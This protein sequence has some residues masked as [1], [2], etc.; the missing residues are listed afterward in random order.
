MGLGDFSPQELRNAKKKDQLNEEEKDLAVRQLAANAS[1]DNVGYTEEAVS[2][3]TYGAG[4]LTT[5]LA[6]YA[7]DS[8]GFDELG[9]SLKK[10]SDSLLKKDNQHTNMGDSLLT[11]REEKSNTST[12][13]AEAAGLALTG[14]ASFLG[15]KIAGGAAKL[16]SSLAKRDLTEMTAKKAAEN[17]AKDLAEKEAID[18]AK[19]KAAREGAE[20]INDIGSFKDTRKTKE[21]LENGEIRDQA[22]DD[23]VNNTL[24]G[25]VNNAINNFAKRVEERKLKKEKDAALKE[26]E[27]V[28]TESVPT[29]RMGKAVNALF[30]TTD[31]MGV[32]KAGTK[33]LGKN[34]VASTYWGVL[35]NVGQGSQQWQKRGEDGN[36]HIGYTDEG[37]SNL[38]LDVTLGGVFDAV[39]GSAGKAYRASKEAKALKARKNST[40]TAG[41]TEGSNMIFRGDASTNKMINEKY[42]SGISDNMDEQGFIDL[43]KSNLV[44]KEK[45][46]QMTNSEKSDYMHEII[47]TLDENG[48]KGGSFR[49]EDTYVFKSPKM[50]T[51]TGEI[52]QNGYMTIERTDSLT[53]QAFGLQT[54]DGPLIDVG[55]DIDVH[56]REMKDPADKAFGSLEP[57]MSFSNKEDG[58]PVLLDKYGNEVPDNVAASKTIKD[59]GIMFDNSLKESGL[60]NNAV[61]DVSVLRQVRNKELENPNHE[62]LPTYLKETVELDGKLRDIGVKVDGLK[63]NYDSVIDDILNDLTDSSKG[64]KGG[65]AK[66][67]IENE[68]SILESMKGNDDY[69]DLLSVDFTQ[70]ILNLKNKDLS[71]KDLSK[72]I[73][74]LVDDT[75]SRFIQ[76]SGIGKDLPGSKDSI[77]SKMSNRFKEAIKKDDSKFGLNTIM[78]EV[79][80]IARY[81]DKYKDITTGFKHET[82]PPKSIIEEKR[83]I[84]DIGE[85]GK[86]LDPYNAKTNNPSLYKQAKREANQVYKPVKNID[87]QVSKIT[88]MVNRTK[89]N[90]EKDPTHIDK[91][92][93]NMF[94]DH[95]IDDINKIH[96]NMKDKIVEAQSKIINDMSDLGEFYNSRGGSKGLEKGVKF[97]SKISKSGRVFYNGSLNPK[98]NKI[99]RALFHQEGD[100]IPLS[101]DDVHVSDGKVH[102]KTDNANKTRTSILQNL[103]VK[104]VD[105]I[106]KPRSKDLDTIWNENIKT[107]HG[108]DGVKFEL[109]D[110]NLG[111]S[112]SG[113]GAKAHLELFQDI[114]NH[115]SGTMPIHIGYDAKA[116]GPAIINAMVGKGDEVFNYNL[117]TKKNPNKAFFGDDP[118]AKLNG[119]IEGRDLQKDIVR[120]AFYMQEPINTARGNFNS[121]V[122]EMFRLGT[123]SK[124][125]KEVASNKMSKLTEL[126]KG[127]FKDKPKDELDLLNITNEKQYTDLQQAYKNLTSGKKVSEDDLNL[128]RESHAKLLK[129]D[130]EKAVEKGFGK[131]M[132]DFLNHSKEFYK[133]QKI[134]FHTKLAEKKNKQEME[135][136]LADMLE[137]LNLDKKFGDQAEKIKADLMENYKNSAYK[138]TSVNDLLDIIG[139]DYMSHE[140]VNS[141]TLKKIIPS[142][143][144]MFGN[145]VPIFKWESS[146]FEKRKGKGAPNLQHSGPS[147]SEKALAGFIIDHDATIATLTRNKDGL[148]LYDDFTN[149]ARAKEANALMGA[150]LVDSK[151]YKA[152]HS[153]LSSEPLGELSKDQI[154]FAAKS[155][156]EESIRVNDLARGLKGKEVDELIKKH[157]DAN[158]I[159]IENSIKNKD[160]FI[161]TLEGKTKEEEIKKAKLKA[162]LEDKDISVNNYNANAT[163]DTMAGSDD[164]LKALDN[165]DKHKLNNKPIEE[166]IVKSSIDERALTEAYKLDKEAV[167]WNNHNTSLNL[168]GSTNRNIKVNI[169]SKNS[170]YKTDGSIHIAVNSK[171]KPR[172]TMKVII[173]EVS[174]KAADISKLENAELVNKFNELR[175]DVKIK[176]DGKYRNIK[177]SDGDRLV[178]NEE[179][180]TR[181]F[182]DIAHSDFIATNT[183]QAVHIQGTKYLDT[184][185][186]TL[187]IKGNDGKYYEIKSHRD[188][189]NFLENGIGGAEGETLANQYIK[190][191]EVHSDL[192][193]SSEDILAFKQGKPKAQSDI[194][195]INSSIIDK[196][197][198]SKIK[199]TEAVKGIHAIPYTDLIEMGQNTDAL[200]MVLSKTQGLD[201]ILNDVVDHSHNK[202]IEATDSIVGE[203]VDRKIGQ[204]VNL[205]AHEFRESFSDGIGVKGFL[206][207]AK[208]E[209]AGSRAEIFLDNEGKTLSN[210]KIKEIDDKLMKTLESNDPNINKKLFDDINKIASDLSNSN[211]K[212]SHTFRTDVMNYAKKLSAYKNLSN[213]TEILKDSLTV[214]NSKGNTKKVSEVLDL[215][216]T[217]KNRNTLFG[218][219]LE[220][221]LGQFNKK[222]VVVSKKSYKG[223][224]GD[225]LATYNDGGKEFVIVAENSRSQF[226]LGK[227]R[228]ELINID[229]SKMSQGIYTIKGKNGVDINIQPHQMNMNSKYTNHSIAN[230]IARNT[231]VKHFD[232]MGR[233]VMEEQYAIGK[234][235][236]LFLD[237]ETFDKLPKEAKEG[238]I[239]SSNKNPLV[240]QFGD[241]YIPKNQAHHFEGT[242]GYDIGK[243]LKD[244]AGDQLGGLLTNGVKA[245]VGATKA[246]KGAILV[247][248]VKS[249]VN[250]YVASTATY[251]VG[252]PIEYANPVS[253]KRFSSEAKNEMKEL[254]KTVKDYTDANLKGDTKRAEAIMKTLEKNDMFFAL[255]HGISQTIRSSAIKNGTLENNELYNMI[256]GNSESGEAIVN[257]LKTTTLDG[258]TKVGGKLAEVFDNTE[259]VPK[260]A[261]YKSHIASGA[262][263]KEAIRS[264]QGYFPNYTNL[265]STLAVIDEFSPFTKYLA[266]WPRIMLYGM[267]HSTVR[268]SSLI[269]A[270][271]TLP[272][273]SFVHTEGQES[274]S[275]N[276]YAK[277]PFFDEAMYTPSMINQSN[278]LANPIKGVG[279]ELFAV[280]ALKSH[281]D[282]YSH[283]KLSRDLIGEQ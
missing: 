168:E 232:S 28:L 63:D 178:D 2:S 254:R 263:K 238:Y 270:G 253:Y 250:S 219:N 231:Y 111:T 279:P 55:T 13:I 114:T 101:I 26:T 72:A 9:A 47:N 10:T 212:V 144:D 119:L 157:T 227:Q 182:T 93:I 23:I 242:D 160:K 162:K 174:H 125:L 77:K 211:V 246:L 140:I 194:G 68:A 245:I 129:G 138:S 265:G 154:E 18:E 207:N 164:I 167:N 104:D 92:L 65:A 218:A 130:I 123:D 62:S 69:K 188:M 19:D 105:N 175:K 147:S 17:E 50:G 118:Y 98:N 67:Q 269:A 133:Q 184:Q 121:V 241:M 52:T 187:S 235:H 137:H 240:K 272:A 46:A 143:E 60:N 42:A 24:G 264:T 21:T 217:T 78:E 94:S 112:Y 172:D 156:A 131:E 249:Y 108:K 233:K 191:V 37:A 280:S 4:A 12:L 120:N 5:G 225:I 116:S 266:A 199:A 59:S 57:D 274:L 25:R 161:K 32:A 260:L 134:N 100:S 202:V 244:N 215:F 30:G 228:T 201:M 148:N 248:R 206:D 224:D 135:A 173:H 276:G 198:V 203:D 283:F 141:N 35:G 102:Y 79:D 205:G 75:M 282:I 81:N 146:R 226:K 197:F 76:R 48:V 169:N 152:F 107:T 214:L 155:M 166:R 204:I 170:K 15:K 179:F 229:S 97:D 222:G 91:D 128:L 171:Q 58:S 271:L 70:S 268:Q 126:T 142:I 213:N 153:S 192:M 223:D 83:H 252:A 36:L 183:D 84:R 106:G 208:R 38:A 239:K 115:G 243:F 6:S 256:R 200:H 132:N 34:A 61:L 39:I 73:D 45:L 54:M 20:D 82:R 277:I 257:M 209:I 85:K 88:A 33:A 181:V 220:N 117:S 261:M 251:M 80:G 221:T 1:K 158:I 109:R 89:A 71:K 95:Y 165:I 44:D 163:G 66:K 22:V 90:L 11:N 267:D 136:V 29:T 151:P 278:P 186:N 113:V 275:D 86:V 74:G 258:D 99:V 185:L 64:L 255:Q 262:S 236:N 27:R 139:N 103:G 14:G 40:I 281:F 3:M 43:S 180:F 210:S 122:D 159:E 150:I 49:L 124:A 31:S 145:K 273:I 110:E 51:V 193:R 41:S 87:V 237:K 16:T 8:L 234:K 149:P 259:L 247:G 216:E 96:P 189:V 176:V 177:E 195:K 7:V 53:D 56:G 196:H 230:T 190:H 127:K